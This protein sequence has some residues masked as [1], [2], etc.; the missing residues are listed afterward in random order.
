MKNIKKIYLKKSDNLG[1]PF[2]SSLNIN[3]LKKILRIKK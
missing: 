1:M 2:N 3:K